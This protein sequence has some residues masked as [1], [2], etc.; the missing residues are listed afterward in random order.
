[1][2]GLALEQLSF[3]TMPDKNWQ[4]SGEGSHMARYM[5]VVEVDL[6]PIFENL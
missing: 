1:M 5:V 4:G 6:E 2:K 3:K